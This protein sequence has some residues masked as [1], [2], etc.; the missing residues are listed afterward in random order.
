MDRAN[1][2]P[3]RF[4]VAAAMLRH[5]LVDPVLP[6]GLLPTDWPADRLRTAYAEFADLLTARRDDQLLEAR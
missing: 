5:L 1:G 4:A 2:V 6:A 3:E